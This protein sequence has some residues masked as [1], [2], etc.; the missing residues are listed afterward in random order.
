MHGIAPFAK[1]R[2]WSKRRGV[3]DEW[4]RAC[5]L[6]HLSKAGAI[7]PGLLQK[8][9]HR[10]R[11]S[12]ERQPLANPA[13]TDVHGSS[14]QRLTSRRTATSGDFNLVTGAW[15]TSE[16]V[17]GWRCSIVEMTLHFKLSRNGERPGGTGFRPILRKK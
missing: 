5:P 7:I 4:V 12:C 17:V 2:G 9:V 14:G 13:G 15:T 6:E 8:Q 10:P 1:D 3:F 11:P 16:K